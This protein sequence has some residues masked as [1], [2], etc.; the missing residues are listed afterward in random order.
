MTIFGDKLREYPLEMIQPS[1]RR[2][3]RWWCH[4]V[5][6]GPIEE[7]HKFAAKIGMQRSWFQA[8]GAQPH[9]DMVLSRRVKALEAGAVEVDTREMFRLAQP[10]GNKASESPV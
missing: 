10:G 3:G 8:H 4:M 5:T 9:Y 7:L 1:A 2:W 6:D